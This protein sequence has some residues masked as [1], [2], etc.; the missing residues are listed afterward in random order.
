MQYFK[1]FNVSCFIFQLTNYFSKSDSYL[2]FYAD[3]HNWNQIYSA[4]IS[5]SKYNTIFLKY[6]TVYG[7]FNKIKMSTDR[8]KCAAD[9]VKQL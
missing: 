8:L 5:L 7:V 6:V 1:S 2:S 3:L 9:D 4:M